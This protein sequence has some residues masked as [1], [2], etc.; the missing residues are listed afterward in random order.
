MSTVL[1]SKNLGISGHSHSTTETHTCGFAVFPHLYVMHVMQ[2]G[3]GYKTAFQQMIIR[4][5]KC[6]E[7]ITNLFVLFDVS[8]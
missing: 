3:E 5:I 7:N 6:T 2:C 8:F 4:Q 1:C